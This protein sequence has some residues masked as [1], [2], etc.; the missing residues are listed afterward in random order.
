MQCLR[1][2]NIKKTFFKKIESP[3]QLVTWVCVDIERVLDEIGRVLGASPTAGEREYTAHAYRYTI[4]YIAVI[5][6]YT[7]LPMYV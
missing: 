7:K 3:P 5:S 6:W 1:S 2:K 4:Y